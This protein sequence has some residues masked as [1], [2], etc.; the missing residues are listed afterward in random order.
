MT[1]KDIPWP[2][3]REK[4]KALTDDMADWTADTSNIE[5]TLRF[6]HKPSRTLAWFTWEYMPFTGENPAMPLSTRKV[7][8]R[9]SLPSVG[10]RIN[11]RDMECAVEGVVDLAYAGIF[12]GS[13]LMSVRRALEAEMKRGLIGKLL[14]LERSIYVYDPGNEDATDVVADD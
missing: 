12:H 13:T 8:E 4:G 1:A 9:H 14:D 5:H 3:W 7:Y 11:S 6:Y 2:T 10:Y